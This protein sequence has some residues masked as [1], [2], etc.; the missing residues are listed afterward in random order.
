MVKHWEHSVQPVRSKV[1]ETWPLPAIW[2]SLPDFRPYPTEVKRQWRLKFLTRP[3]CPVRVGLS[4]MYW[5]FNLS[6]SC[7]GFRTPWGWNFEE[8][9][10][11]TTWVWGATFPYVS[12]SQIVY[13][14]RP[15][16]ENLSLR[17]TED[18]L[19]LLHI[20]LHRILLLIWTATTTLTRI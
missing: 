19:F 8:N 14:L 13:P 18:E 12:C 17:L 10:D 1:L 4:V 7:K 15:K 16:I 3:G 5:T 2:L 6:H 11:R 20:F 9:Q